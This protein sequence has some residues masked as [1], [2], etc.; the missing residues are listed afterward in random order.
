[1]QSFATCFS[2]PRTSISYSIVICSSISLVCN[3]LLPARAIEWLTSAA[4]SLMPVKHTSHFGTQSHLR[5]RPCSGSSVTPNTNDYC[6]RRHATW[7]L[8]RVAIWNLYV[9]LSIRI[10][11]ISSIVTIKNLS[12]YTHV[13]NTIS[14]PWTEYSSLYGTQWQLNKSWE[15]ASPQGRYNSP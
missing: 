3:R 11:L 8:R 7:C 4:S 12:P 1:M 10:S 9:I 2:G 14:S 5:S 15:V 13:Q 6:C